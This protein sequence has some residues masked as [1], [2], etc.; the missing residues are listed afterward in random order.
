MPLPFDQHLYSYW[1]VGARPPY[2][3]LQQLFNVD[4]L[5]CTLKALD[6]CK[7]LPLALCFP[8]AD[9]ADGFPRT[10]DDSVATARFVTTNFCDHADAAAF[11]QAVAHSRRGLFSAVY[12]LLASDAPRRRSVVLLRRDDDAATLRSTLLNAV[13]SVIR[14]MAAVSGVPVVFSDYAV[15]VLEEPDRCVRGLQP[16]NPPRRGCKPHVSPPF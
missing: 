13:P 6:T 1:P 5:E 7:T 15:S 9:H 2:K 16:P 3:P 10:D 12:E 14:A 11:L 4:S 8:R